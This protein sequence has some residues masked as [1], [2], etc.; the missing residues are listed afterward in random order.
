M[1]TKPHKPTYPSSILRPSEVS[2]GSCSP[3]KNE[4]P[5]PEDVSQSLTAN[6]S[7]AEMEEAQKLI[8]EIAVRI[9]LATREQEDE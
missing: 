1:L 8:A 5:A 4:L 6:V 7:S 2:A 3:S 9:F